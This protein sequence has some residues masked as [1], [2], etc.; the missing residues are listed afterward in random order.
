[1]GFSTAKD[2]KGA[3]VD[4]FGWPGSWCRI[5]LT[6]VCCVGVAACGQEP[7]ATADE[8]PAGVEA[9][10]LISNA[11][12]YTFDPGDTVIASGA[13]A[14]SADGAIVA[15]GDPD[16]MLAAYP[17]ARRID[18]GGRTVLP[19]LID[20]HGHLYGLA[21]SLTRADLVGTRS[22]EDLLERLRAFEAGLAA[23]EWLLGRGWD[24]NDWPEPVFPD[25]ADLDA[26]FP[27]RPVWLERIDGHAAW[28]NSR[29]IAQADRD[30]SGDWQPE[31]GFIHRDP[32]GAATGI[33]VD[34]AMALVERAVPATS[35]ERMDAALNRA[36][37]LLASL[38]LTGVHDPGVD[39]AIVEIYREKIADGTL[40]LRIYALADGPGPTLDWLCEHGR[41]QDPS[42]RLTLRAVKLYADGALGSR[43]AALLDDYAD[44]PGNRGLLFLAD[45]QLEEQLRRVLSCGLQAGVHA[46][47]DRAN[48][49]V[50]DA[51]QRLLPE[52]PDNPGRHRIEHAQV[53]DPADIPRFA[54]L[55]VIAAMQPSHA[56]SD[57]YW[58]DERLGEARLAGAY[59]WRSLLGSGATL[60]FGSDFPVEQVNPILGIYAAVTRRDL[61]GWPAEG[62]QPQERL[63][64]VEAFRAYTLDAA[65]AAFMEDAVGSLEPGKRADFIVLDRDPL[66]V[67]EAEIPTV[68]VLQ[69]WLDAVRVFDL[70]AAGISGNGR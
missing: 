43:G 21:Q 54:R 42:G 27:D 19:G 1:V 16:A 52:F 44:Q 29:A 38:G 22:K 59:A 32:A 4:K 17:D 23:D 5:A 63:S 28:G 70:D 56:T 58:A 46:I 14:F 45:Q 31:G 65:R 26:A 60:A 50:L 8:N 47:G 37:R 64:R 66:A 15:L 11:R 49:Q 68:R 62:W 48:R 18:L 40:P 25:R 2:A 10:T 20:S 51:Y 53:V 57:M 33:F 12:I 39:R 36:G 69:T 24:Q 61:D 13:M 55:G 67:P 35:P 3:K 30:L 9:F 7:G 34:G 41:Q 6:A